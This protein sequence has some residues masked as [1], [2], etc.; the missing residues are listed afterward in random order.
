MI[1]NF[2]RVSALRVLSSILPISGK[3]RKERAGVLVIKTCDSIKESK[4]S[5]AHF[6]FRE[7]AGFLP[8]SYSLSWQL[9]YNCPSSSAKVT[10]LCGDGRELDRFCRRRIP[11]AA[12]TFPA[13][14]TARIS[15][16]RF[17][18]ILPLF[19][20]YCFID[21]ATPVETALCDESN[22]AKV[23]VKCTTKKC[24]DRPVLFTLVVSS[25]DLRPFLFKTTESRR[26]RKC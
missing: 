15:S 8:F 6:L 24:G 14:R 5:H 1:L 16:S 13:W 4:Q 11:P 17:G 10:V 23:H 25:K 20:L 2:S 26:R 12:E 19:F 9:I 7:F 18:A 21:F 22:H 3:E